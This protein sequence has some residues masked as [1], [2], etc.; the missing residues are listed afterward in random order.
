MGERKEA[1][2][3][4]AKASLDAVCF[5]GNQML[6]SRRRYISFLVQR[7]YLYYCAVFAALA[8]AFFALGLQ[9]LFLVVFFFVAFF[10][11]TLLVGFLAVSVAAGAVPAVCAETAAGTTNVAAAKMIA[12]RNE[13]N[14]LLIPFSSSKMPPVRET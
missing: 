7:R 2:A 6:L 9:A 8:G 10:F 11:V 1:R 4:S 12:V 14:L 3:V 13:T 5:A